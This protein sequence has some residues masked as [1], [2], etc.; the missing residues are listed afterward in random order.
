MSSVNLGAKLATFAGHLTIE[1]R[2]GSIERG[3]GDLFATAATR[4]G[5]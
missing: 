5:V 2:A 4:R 1:R 3:P